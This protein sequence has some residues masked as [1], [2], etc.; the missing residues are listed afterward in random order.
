MFEYNSSTY[1]TKIDDG[2]S[3]FVDLLMMPLFDLILINIE[4][5]KRFIDSSHTPTFLWNISESVFPKI[6]MRKNALNLV[7][8]AAAAV[9]SIDQVHK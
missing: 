7:V 5:Q 2:F 3:L 9:G 4:P 6:G 1:K 8:V